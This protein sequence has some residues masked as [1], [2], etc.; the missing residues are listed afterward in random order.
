MG[1]VHCMAATPRGGKLVVPS[2][3]PPRHVHSTN[4]VDR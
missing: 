4:V 3:M 1:W 2:D